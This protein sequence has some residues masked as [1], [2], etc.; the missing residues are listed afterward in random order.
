MGVEA[1]KQETI[2]RISKKAPSSQPFYIKDL[3][4]GDEWKSIDVGTRKFLGRLIS[5]AVKNGEIPRTVFY[6]ASKPGQSTR[7]Q[8]I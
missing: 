1:L 6:P 4:T 2:D 3:F 5:A 8:K 7:Y